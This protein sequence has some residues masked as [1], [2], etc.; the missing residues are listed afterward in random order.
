MRISGLIR[1][2]S[3]GAV[4]CVRWVLPEVLLLTTSLSLYIVCGRQRKKDPENI[5]I[6]V[7]RTDST[8]ESHDP[9]LK[10]K[11]NFLTAIGV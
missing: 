11:F 7:T 2:D 9:A 10:S 6:D 3:I 4:D 5:H 1:L 8:T